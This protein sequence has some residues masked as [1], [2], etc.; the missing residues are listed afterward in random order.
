MAEVKTVKELRERH[1]RE[2]ED[3]QSRCSH[4]NSTWMLE[5]MFE[6]HFTGHECR[7]CEVCEKT[8]EKRELPGYPFNIDYDAY[9]GM[10]SPE[11][12]AK[13]WGVKL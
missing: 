9:L 3:F 10:P 12:L 7:V 2:I 11:E 4:T 6:A 8:L 13:K 1:K 5:S